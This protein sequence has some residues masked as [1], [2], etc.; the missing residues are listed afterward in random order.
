M[1]VH[2]TS[3]KTCVIVVMHFYYN[4][5]KNHLRKNSALFDLP[6]LVLTAILWGVA[7]RAQEGTTVVASYAREAIW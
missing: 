4:Y 5:T 1:T 6:I 7:S 3:A 2:Q